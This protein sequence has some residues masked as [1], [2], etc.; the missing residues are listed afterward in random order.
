MLFRSGE[1]GGETWK[2]K[3][4]AYLTGG[5]ALWVTGSYDVAAHRTFWGVGNP[6]PM[7]D[8]FYRPGDNLYTNSVIVLDPDDGKM[9]WHHQYTPGDMWDYDEVGSHILIDAEVGGQKRTLVTHSARNGFLY[10]FERGNGQTV[11]AKPYIENVN[12][13]KGID[14][15]TGKI[16]RAHV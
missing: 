5:G 16:G 7:L 14:Q 12:W 10:T 1:P 3:N 15:K 2:D 11:F 8:P 6:V 4:N 9:L 13:T